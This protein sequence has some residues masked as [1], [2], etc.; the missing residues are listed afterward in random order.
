MESS[1]NDRSPAPSGLVVG[2]DLW[3]TSKATG[4][5][6]DLGYPMRPAGDPG[7][8]RRLIEE[9]R[10][11]L[12][13]VNLTA[14]DLAAPAALGEYRRLAGPSAWLVAVGPHVNAERLAA[15]RAAGCQLALPR[16]KF[17]AD[18]PGLLRRCFDRPADSEVPPG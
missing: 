7:T 18:L 12:I 5:A 17:A 16:S 11:R 14:G 10:P 3:F 15:A 4:T 2:R 9:C 8:V 6:S 13:L 1:S